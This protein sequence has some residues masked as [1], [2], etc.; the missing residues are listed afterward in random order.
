MLSYLNLITTLKIGIIMPLVGRKKN[1]RLRMEK[2]LAS[3]IH[4]VTTEHQPGDRQ[5]AECLRWNPQNRQGPAL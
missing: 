4:S 5:C 1:L 3:F 2:W